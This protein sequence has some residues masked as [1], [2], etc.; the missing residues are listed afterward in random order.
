M[1]NE[2]AVK[3]TRV[4]SAKLNT[5]PVEDGQIIELSDKAAWYYD[6][7]NTRYQLGQGHTIENPAGT[8][9][10][11]RENMQFVDSHLADDSTNNRTKIETIKTVTS[12][13]FDIA[14][15]DGLYNI[16]DGTT[17]P[18]TASDVGYDNTSSGLAA[19]DVQDAIDELA[20]GAGGHEIVNSSGTTLAQ[21]PAMQF[22]D[23]HLSDDSTNDRTVVEVIKSVASA[24]YSS[25]TEHGMYLIPDGE[26]AT[27]EPASDDYVE[28]TA[29]GVKTYA[30]LLNELY[31]LINNNKVTLDTK[32]V[33]NNSGLQEIYD[34]YIIQSSELRFSNANTD[35]STAYINRIKIASVYS[36]YYNNANNTVTNKSNDIPTT[37]T[38]LTLYYGNKK[39]T[40]DLQTTA[41]RC[42]YDGN[43]TVKQKIDAINSTLSQELY[44]EHTTREDS[45]TSN[46]VDAQNRNF[47]TE[48]YYTIVKNHKQITVRIAG[49]SSKTSYDDW[50]LGLKNGYKPAKDEYFTY[51]LGSSSYTG[52][53]NPAGYIRFRDLNTTDVLSATITFNIA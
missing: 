49:I 15:E 35:S 22:V 1:A 32:L 3:H 12:A 41:N 29:D 20:S 38:K 21:E 8:D 13:Q 2:I 23:S 45:I 53:V 10:T 14:T 39:A 47:L 52:H 4:T 16:S 28:V 40:V 11:Q 50:I 42:W 24:N 43:T 48:G 34:I 25:E 5:V 36:T 9:M 46:I 18:L 30:A 19:T 37:G 31:S 17:T 6:S 33:S 26:G 51:C 7:G 27:I 44:E